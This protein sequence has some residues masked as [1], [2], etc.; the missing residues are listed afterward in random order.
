MTGLANRTLAQR[1]LE[2]ALDRQVRRGGFTGLLFC[3]LDGFKGVNDT[4]GHQAGDRLL[5]AVAE[6]LRLAVR[7]TDTPARYGGDEFVVVCDGLTRPEDAEVLARRLLA[8]VPGEYDLPGGV[9]TIGV[10]IGVAVA[11]TPVPAADLLR[12]ADTNMYVAKGTGGN[13]YRVSH[14]AADPP[15]PQ[16]S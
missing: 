16:A 12:A 3:D 11:D 4:F 9:A 15:R 2:R 14:L 6:R 1:E 7:S 13:H 10:S 5:V 8:S